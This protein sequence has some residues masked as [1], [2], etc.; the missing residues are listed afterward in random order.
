ME[1][2]NTK[3]IYFTAGAYIFWGVL[4][5]YW[6]IIDQISALE[7]LAHRVIWSFIFVLLIVGLIKRKLLKN[8]FQVQMKQRKTWFG[9]LLASVLISINWFVYIFAVNANHIVEASLGYFINPLVAVLLG[10]FVLGEK[11]NRWQATSFVVAGIGVLYMTLSLGTFPWIA[12]IL[13]LSFGF[14]GLSKKLIKV[15]SILGLLLETLFIVP[16]AL[17]FLA[18]LGINGQYSFASGSLKN[19]LFLLGSGIATALPL[20]WFGIGA[21]KIPLYLVGLLQYIAPTISLLLGVFIYGESFTN[22]H[23]VTFTFIWIAL[24]IFSISNI[25]QIIKKRKISPTATKAK[26]A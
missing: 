10:V 21:Q 5:I 22:D 15:D 14:Y 18:Y 3:G 2:E 24:A 6:K 23:A 17:L 13:A 25:Q 7:I 11:M 26:S 9:L 12:L 1:R 4:P 16:F 19:D 20:L 8:F